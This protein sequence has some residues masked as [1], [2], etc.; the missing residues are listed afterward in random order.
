[1]KVETTICKHIYFDVRDF[2]IVLFYYYYYCA[3][4]NSF[5]NRSILLLLFLLLRYRDVPTGR[6]TTG[7][8]K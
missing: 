4:N 5:K 1:M 2:S 3:N 8:F 6:Y 7:Y